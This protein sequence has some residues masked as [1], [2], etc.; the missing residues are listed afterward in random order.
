MA[1][2]DV[3]ALF[4]QISEMEEQ[5]RGEEDLRG[6][7]VFVGWCMGE[8]CKEIRR[9]AGLLPDT[10]T[11]GGAAAAT[12]INVEGEGLEGT[13]EDYLTALK[14]KHSK[15][16]E[17][18]RY[19]GTVLGKDMGEREISIEGGE[20]ESIGAWGER[21]RE[22]WKPRGGSEEK[23]EGGAEVVEMGSDSSSPLSEISREAN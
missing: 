2:Q 22:R 10:A 6:V 17:E 3:G 18:S 20:V 15:T 12:A 7:E 4:P 21:L 16:G 9:I 8:G 19:Q 14:K 5:A 23:G 1:L 13:R 11:T